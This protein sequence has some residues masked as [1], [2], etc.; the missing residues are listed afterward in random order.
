MKKWLCLIFYFL[1]ATVNAHE[2][3]H[4]TPI[5]VSVAIDQSALLWRVSVQDGFVQVAKSQ[6]FKTFSTP[7]KVNQQAQNISLMGETRPKIAIGTHGEIYVAW[8]QNLKPRF[9]G[10]I[11]FARSIDGGKSFEKPYVVHQDRAEIGHAF[12]V[13]QVTAD[14]NITI[15][16]LDSRDSLAAKKANS[17]FSGSSIY[18]AT[19]SNKGQSFG[20]E[21]KLSDSTCECCRI[22]T[23]AKPDSTVVALWRHVFEGGERDHMIAEIPKQA[24]QAP[25]FKRASYGHWKIDGCP[26]HGAAIVAGGE[27]KDWWGYHIA[28]FDGND[29]NPGLYYGRVD[30]EAWAFSPPKK[31]G[32]NAKR[33]EHPALLSVTDKTG[34]ENFWLVWRETESKNSIIKG[35]FS[36]DGGRSW[37][38]PKELASSQGKTDYPQLISNKQQVYLVWNTSQD[39]LR[40]LPLQ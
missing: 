4:T 6:D 12:E 37:Q 25:V 33:A 7:V 5:A 28:Y 11:W 13:M 8:M 9:S 18:Y 39:G 17:P 1:Y 36:D 15:V 26:H 35:Q 10:Y 29:K 3:N 16:W 20:V 22:A 30:G 14:G 27:G 2:A 32:D 21:Q 23:A 31:F 24:G 40:I 34:A 38:A 19:S